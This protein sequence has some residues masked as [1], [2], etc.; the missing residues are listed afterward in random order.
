MSFISNYNVQL[1]SQKLHGTAVMGTHTV[2]AQDTAYEEF[3]HQAYIPA[4]PDTLTVN[5]S[6]VSE[7]KIIMVTSENSGSLV[8]Y[9]QG[10]GSDYYWCDPI[11]VLSFTSGMTWGVGDLTLVF[12]NDGT[13]EQ[14]VRIQAFE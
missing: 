3:D 14:R 4:G 5:L 11:S 12:S 13:Q 2:V 9:R 1:L 10:S 7:P 6:G 8:K